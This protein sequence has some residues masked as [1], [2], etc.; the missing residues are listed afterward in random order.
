MG[1]IPA[2]VMIIIITPEATSAVM[3]HGHDELL[4]IYLR[5][6]INKLK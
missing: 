6:L 5:N 2:V 4:F 1:A 3:N